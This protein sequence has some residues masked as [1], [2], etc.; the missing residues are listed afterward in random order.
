M[1]SRFFYNN[2]VKK[3]NCKIC[4]E[5]ESRTERSGFSDTVETIGELQPQAEISDDGLSISRNDVANARDEIVS[6]A[7]GLGL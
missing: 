4:I 3:K 2:L 1:E 5:N 6:W 7:R